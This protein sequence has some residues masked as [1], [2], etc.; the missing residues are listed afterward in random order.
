M[1]AFHNARLLHRPLAAYEAYQAT[2]ED[3]AHLASLLM[4]NPNEK[5]FAAWFRESKCDVVLSHLP[6]AFEW[7]RKA[8]ARVPETHGFCLLNVENSE[9]PCAGLDLQP[10]LIGERSM[11]MLVAMV[12]RGER[13]VPVQPLTT[14]VPAKWVHGP[15]V[16]NLRKPGDAVPESGVWKWAPPSGRKWGELP[17][18]D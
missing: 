5:E 2:H 17:G 1:N 7:M 12:L 6:E 15:T 13:G 4:W 8:G 10:R 9:V 14:L 11:E 3:T 16:R 18:A